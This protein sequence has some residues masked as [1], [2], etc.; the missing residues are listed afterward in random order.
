[1][2][3]FKQNILASSMLFLAE[4]ATAG[5]PHYGPASWYYPGLGA[6]AGW[7]G[8]GDIVVALPPLRYGAGQHCG[9]NIQV[10][11]QGKTVTAKVVDLCPSCVMDEIDLSMG[12]FQVLAPLDQG[13]IQVDWEYV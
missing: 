10:H 8:D 13:I 4:I 1:M 6:C 7:S 3:F 11:Y 9:K 5:K 12:A 2:M